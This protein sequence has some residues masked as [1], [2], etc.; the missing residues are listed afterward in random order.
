MQSANISKQ[1]AMAAV[2]DLKQHAR[3]LLDTLS[4]WVSSSSSS[5][6]PELQAFLRSNVSPDIVFEFPTIR[7][8]GIESYLNVWS[9]AWCLKTVAVHSATITYEGMIADEKSVYIEFIPHIRFYLMPWVSIPIRCVAV[10]L[11]F[12]RTLDG[13]LLVTKHVDHILLEG[14]GRTFLP[15][16]YDILIDTLGVLSSWFGGAVRGLLYPEHQQ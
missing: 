10:E 7:V 13:R 11:H 15:G 14:L 6:F 5:S 3:S 9:I 12:Q 2:I 8:K 16:V 4:G 1:P